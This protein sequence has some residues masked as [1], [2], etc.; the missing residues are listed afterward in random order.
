MDTF[1]SPSSE[2]G[3]VWDARFGVAWVDHAGT[4]AA[5]APDGDS[6]EGLPSEAGRWS[7]GLG[8]SARASAAVVFHLSWC[9][10]ARVQS[11]RLVAWS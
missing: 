7:C 10:P 9:S 5:V 6:V 4:V 1:R 11:W 3:R 8:A 2:L